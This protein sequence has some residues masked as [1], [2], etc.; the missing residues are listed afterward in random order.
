MIDNK[1]FARLSE[2][3]KFDF[4]EEG[5]A[6]FN[7]ELNEIAE[8]VSKVCDFGGEYDDIADNN[9][10]TF[11]QLREDVSVSTATPEQLLANTESLNNCYI[12]PKVIG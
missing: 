4:T 5:G 9:H 3:S 7:S 1:T 11:S 6:R 2:L 10:V 8:F 12:I